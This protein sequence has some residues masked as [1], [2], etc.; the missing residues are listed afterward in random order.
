MI[1]DVLWTSI[2]ISLCLILALAGLIIALS[3]F[4]FM[5]LVFVYPML[6]LL[7]PNCALTRYHAFLLKLQPRLFGWLLPKT[8]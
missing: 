3:G 6:Y 7:G 8:A 5:I 4:V 1:S 2:S